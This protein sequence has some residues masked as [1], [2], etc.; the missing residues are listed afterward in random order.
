MDSSEL[1][2]AVIKEA[3]D[4]SAPELIDADLMRL[5]AQRGAESRKNNLLTVFVWIVVG[6]IIG[7]LSGFLS[8]ELFPALLVVLSLAFFTGSML[9]LPCSQAYRKGDYGTALTKIA[10][11]KLWNILWS[12]FTLYQYSICLRLE[13][14]SLLLEGRLL[15][16][17][18]L[19]RYHWAL[20]EKPPLPE[21]PKHFAFANDIGISWMLRNKNAEAAAMFSYCLEKKMAN[22]HRL[23]VLN[24]LAY[25]QVR[26]AQLK[27]ALATLEQ[28]FE[29]LGKRTI[30]VEGSRLYAI[31]ARLFLAQ[32]NFRAAEEC[33]LEAEKCKAN[34]KEFKG[35][36]T[37]LLARARQLE[38]R[39]DEAD[40]HYKNGIDICASG[41]N[42]DYLALAEN[43]H[44]YA[45]LL[46]DKGEPEE[47][48]KIWNR[49]QQY[50]DYYVERE[51][52][53]VSN[54]R[55]RLLDKKRIRVST[56]LLTVTKPQK[57]L[58]ELD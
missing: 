49:A 57:F 22:P 14:N 2:Y 36:L 35:M 58:P 1:T 11:A 41:K 4:Y 37:I 26:S 39:L 25:C 45:Q 6:G 34:V 3:P 10:T 31:K 20:S 53:A 32:G 33:I 28:A 47:A 16:L 13:A 52:S 46:L 5:I 44:Y 23:I 48:R 9:L 54:F 38:G 8:I 15:E 19:T 27:E 17:E 42:P 29:L 24:N 7:F 12:P 56:D 21:K 40:L 51:R 55:M 30:S 43:L 18:L 50:F